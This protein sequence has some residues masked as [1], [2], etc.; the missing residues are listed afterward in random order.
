MMNEILLD[1]L[2]LI[3]DVITFAVPDDSKNDL[4]YKMHRIKDKIEGVSDE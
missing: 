4:Y 3:D 2:E 1:I